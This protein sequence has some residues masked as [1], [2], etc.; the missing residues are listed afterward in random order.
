[1]LEFVHESF[2]NAT[3]INARYAPTLGDR[4]EHV[5]PVPSKWLEGVEF[6]PDLFNTFPCWQ[7]DDIF[8]MFVTYGIERFEPLQIW[9]L[10]PLREA[11]LGRLGRK[12]KVELRK[13][14]PRELV[15]D[16]LPLSVRAG[17]RCV[18]KAVSPDRVPEV[19]PKLSADAR[20][21]PLAVFTEP[22]SR[23]ARL[24]HAMIFAL[25]PR[26]GEREGA[27]GVPVGGHQAV[28]R[29]LLAGL[30]TLKAP[31]VYN[32]DLASCRA[33]VAMVLAST[34]T[35]RQVLAWKAN[36]G[37]QRVFAGPNLVVRPS[38]HD[39]IL[40]SEAIDKVIVPSKWVADAYVA[41]APELERKIVIWPAGVDAGWWAP[42]ASER[43]SILIYDKMLPQLADMAAQLARE[44]GWKVLRI[45]YGEYSPRQFRAALARARTCVYL[46]ESES[47][48]IAL[49]EAWS[50][51]VPTLVLKRDERFIS[52]LRMRVSVA[53][54][55]TKDTGAFWETTE[56]L[57]QL[58]DSSQEAAYSPR[59]WLLNHMTD[60]ESTRILLDL[61]SG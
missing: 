11:F 47:Q 29:S 26:R 33:D 22:P 6:A 14:R 3:R 34:A 25:T 1:M 38:D 5:S 24:R 30:R 44:T 16:A 37:C 23:R 50:M 41:E 46:S 8:A 59:K 18:R 55:L 40:R 36:G 9:H 4:R 39:G 21:C 35:L 51:N 57:R 27:C 2:S 49:A 43:D 54:Y 58:L 42:P 61:A 45:K 56:D 32:P 48:G 20:H 17:F 28:T 53:P 15:R 19:S 52:G 60:V 7:Y 12:P 31:F 10:D 13:R